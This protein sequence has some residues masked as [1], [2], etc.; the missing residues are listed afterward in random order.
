MTTTT[1]LLRSYLDIINEANVQEKWGTTTTV[2]PS[3]KGK[4]AGKSKSELLKAYHQLKNSGPHHK[5]S[6]EYEKMK[7]LGFA[8]RAKSDW[9]QVE[10]SNDLAKKDYDQDGEIESEK[11]EVWGSRFRAAKLAK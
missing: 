2:S 1:Q 7:E 11:D 5:G 6:P 8:I 4:Y 10:S 9:G 3:E